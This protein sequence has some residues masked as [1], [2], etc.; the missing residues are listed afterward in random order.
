VGQGFSPAEP[1]A[2]KGCPTRPGSHQGRLVTVSLGSGGVLA[3]GTR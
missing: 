1:A 3:G 2:L